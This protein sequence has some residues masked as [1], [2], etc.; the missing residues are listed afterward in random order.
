M[1]TGVYGMNI[2]VKD[3][4]AAVKKYEGLLGVKPLK[5]VGEEEFAFPGLKGAVFDVGG[6]LIHLV[7]SVADNTSI[8]KFLNTKGEGVFLVSLRSDNV[9][10]DT[11]RITEAGAV[12]VLDKPASGKF[13]TVNFIHPKSAHGVQMEIYDPEV[14]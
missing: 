11:E 8:A 1:I 14:K 3:L 9:Q 6:F 2:A 10:E 7:T 12:F 4:D 13:G 5:F